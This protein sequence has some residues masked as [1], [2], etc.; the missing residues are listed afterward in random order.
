ML[1]KNFTD[2]EWLNSNIDFAS[3]NKF[4]TDYANEIFGEQRQTNLA[5]LEKKLKRKQQNRKCN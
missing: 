3:K 2:V 5:K 4:Y 1:G